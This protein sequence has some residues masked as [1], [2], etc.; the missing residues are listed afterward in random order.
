MKTFHPHLSIFSDAA[1]VNFMVLFVVIGNIWGCILLY[2]QKYIGFQ[3]AIFGAVFCEIF[4]V[5]PNIY[6]VVFDEL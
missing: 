1:G 3:L 4:V 6:R 5:F 2:F